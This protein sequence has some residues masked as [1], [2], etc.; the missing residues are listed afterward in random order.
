MCT[1]LVS[2][3]F[4]PPA[5]DVA[6]GIDDK[7]ALKE[8]KSNDNGTLVLVPPT[9]LVATPPSLLIAGSGAKGSV[10]VVLVGENEVQV[11]KEDYWNIQR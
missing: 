1:L 3:T 8:L 2:H 5:V 9:S 10:T 6:V 4:P 7:G 11:L